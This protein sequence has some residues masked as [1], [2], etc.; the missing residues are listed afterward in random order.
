MNKKVLIVED[1]IDIRETLTELL[2]D[3]GHEVISAENGQVA[4]DKLHAETVQPDVI[5]LDLMMPIKNGFQFCEEKQMDSK[6]RHIPII[7][8]SAD[9]HIRDNMK[10]I[11]AAAYLRKPLDIFEM[12]NA[13]NEHAL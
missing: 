11:S 12:L 5:I 1:D 13:I 7:V 3:E 8:M 9:G 10:L 6:L 2:I 4:L